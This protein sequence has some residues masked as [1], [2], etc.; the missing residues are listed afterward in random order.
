LN[1]W[2]FVSL[3]PAPSIDDADGISERTV[4]PPQAGLRPLKGESVSARSGRSDDT[5]GSAKHLRTRVSS[6][7]FVFFHGEEN[8]QSKKE[9]SRL[10]WKADIKTREQRR[11][12]A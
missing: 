3:C 11:P 9:A 6:C 5:Q 4:Y 7:G 12:K 1:V 10:K 8:E 2:F